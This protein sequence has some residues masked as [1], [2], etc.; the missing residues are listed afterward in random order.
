LIT[1]WPSLFSCAQSA[2]PINP[3]APVTAIF[4]CLAKLET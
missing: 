1:W 3:D 2:L 4:F